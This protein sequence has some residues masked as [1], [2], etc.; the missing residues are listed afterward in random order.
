MGRVPTL[1]I[2]YSKFGHAIVSIL[3]LNVAVSFHDGF[4]LMLLYYRDMRKN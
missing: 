2:G 3:H 4:S 1:R